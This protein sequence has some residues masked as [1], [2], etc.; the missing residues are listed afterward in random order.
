MTKKTTILV[1]GE[2]G[3]MTSKEKRARQLI[4][5]GQDIALWK[6][7]KLLDA[8]GLNEQPPF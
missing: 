1:V 2:W 4:E 3:S 8:L 6:A 5:Q 7:D